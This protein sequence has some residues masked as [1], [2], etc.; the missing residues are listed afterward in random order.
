MNTQ[1][2]AMTTVDPMAALHALL[3]VLD[4][5]A[6]SDCDRVRLAFDIAFQAINGR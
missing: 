5:D 3:S 1:T 2:D 6:L 4:D